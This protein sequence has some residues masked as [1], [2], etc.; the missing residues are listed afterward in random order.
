M[1]MIAAEAEDLINLK[2]LGNRVRN[3][4]HRHLALELVDGFREMFG[5]LLIEVR[6]HLIEDQDLRALEYL[7]FGTQLFFI[8][9]VILCFYVQAFSGV[10]TKSIFCLSLSLF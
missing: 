9:V 2:A 4:Q 8:N 7:Q 3:E 6:D 1:L 5:G 10:L